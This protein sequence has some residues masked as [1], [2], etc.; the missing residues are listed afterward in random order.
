MLLLLLFDDEQV[1][2][3]GDEVMEG[4]GGVLLA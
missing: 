2:R 1:E 3:V 4:E